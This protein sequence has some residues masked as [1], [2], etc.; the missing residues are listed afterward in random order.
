MRPVYLNG[1]V[2]NQPISGVERYGQEVFRRLPGN[3]K[4]L[5]PPSAFRGALGHLWEQIYLPGRVG[6]NGFLYSPAN[7]APLLAINQV[8]TIHDVSVL[9][10]PEWFRPDFAR[11]YR[12]LIPRLARRASAVITDSEFS[13]GRIISQCQIPSEKIYTI[14]CGVDF[15]RFNGAP[16]GTQDQDQIRQTFGLDREYILSVGTIE[17]R[18]NLQMLLQAWKSIRNSAASI[19]L[20]IAG[21]EKAHIRAGRL[22]QEDEG[23]IF[24]GRVPDEFLPGLY[25]GATAFIYPSIYEGFGLPILEAMA[26]GTPV[27]A[28][29]CTAIPEVVGSAGLLVDPVDVVNLASAITRLLSDQSLRTRLAALGKERAA[30]Y[31]WQKTAD[32]IWEVLVTHAD[33]A[34]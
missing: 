32:R 21:G 22:S 7:T 26:C 18:K 24:L 8:V 29:N 5:K 20:A 16:S 33:R 19:V 28:S 6:N 15:G 34:G 4:V 23:V 30:L 2:L 1:R 9:D 25:A 17:P 31:S 27:I 14:P 12:F 10:C 3:F 11:W 13:K